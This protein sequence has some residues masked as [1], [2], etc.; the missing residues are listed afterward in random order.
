MSTKAAMSAFLMTEVSKSN[1]KVDT[2]KAKQITFGVMT[3]FAYLGLIMYVGRDPHNFL[4]TFQGNASF[5]AEIS[6]LT[7]VFVVMSTIV[8]T[9]LIAFKRTK[10]GRKGYVMEFPYFSVPSDTFCPTYR[11]NYYMGLVALSIASF[12]LSVGFVNKFFVV[13]SLL[14]LENAAST[15]FI[16]NGVT[17]AFGL[18]A[19][20]FIVV[21]GLYTIDEQ[22]QRF[23]HQV[24]VLGGFGGLAVYIA[25]VYTTY[26]VGGLNQYLV[27]QSF[28]HSNA[29]LV[30]FAVIAFGICDFM[31]TRKEGG[32]LIVRSSKI[33]Y[34]WWVGFTVSEL[35]F[36]LVTLTQIG[37]IMPGEL[38][39]MS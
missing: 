29:W 16:A 13:Q 23:Y 37:L 15:A 6:G 19:A 22:P 27:D 25:L 30:V 39:T 36:I 34:M 9:Y 28:S 5:W 17:L 10:E 18:F 11:T 31:T 20:C 14:V 2:F 21:I 24:G 3:I 4:P 12:L 38:A 35:F 26:T 32:K 1:I 7:G 8:Q 33:N